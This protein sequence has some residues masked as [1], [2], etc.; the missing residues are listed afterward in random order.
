MPP[1]LNPLP[2]GGEGEKKSPL[3]PGGGGGGGGGGGAGPGGGGFQ[4]GRGPRR[5]VPSSPDRAVARGN[6]LGACRRRAAAPGPARRR[7]GGTGPDHRA[8]R[9]SEGRH[10]DPPP[11]PYLTPGSSPPPETGRAAG[12]RADS[13][14]ARADP[15]AR[16]GRGDPSR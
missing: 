15:S 6:S 11:R 16:R 12:V 7:R 1:H 3:P 8:G 4:A 13:L 2:T 14:G 9:P 10:P 5:L